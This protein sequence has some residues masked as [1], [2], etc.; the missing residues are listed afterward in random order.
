MKAKNK[1]QKINVKNWILEKYI[2]L[3]DFQGAKYY[4]LNFQ[5]TEAEK[6]WTNYSIIVHHLK[7][8]LSKT[9]HLIV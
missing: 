4:P 8:A 3:S 2:E 5:P 7:R 6:G 9:E 1:G